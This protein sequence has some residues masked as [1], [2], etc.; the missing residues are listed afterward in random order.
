MPQQSDDNDLT[1]TTV[2]AGAVA[3]VIVAG[4]VDITNAAQLSGAGRSALESNP[5]EL[6]FDLTAVT[7]MDSSGLGH[8]VRVLH[9]A[10][11]VPVRVLV[12]HPSLLRLFDITGLLGAFDV[13]HVTAAPSTP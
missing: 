2:S 11:P 10:R 7:F 8:L 3:S 4:E 13:Q 9:A 6:V 12:T 1:I 5:A